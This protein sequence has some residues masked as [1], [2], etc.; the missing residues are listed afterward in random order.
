M[1]ADSAHPKNSSRIPAWQPSLNEIARVERA[2]A[3]W[4]PDANIPLNAVIRQRSGV[5]VNNVPLEEIARRIFGRAGSIVDAQC[6]DWRL[7]GAEFIISDLKLAFTF[8]DIARTS[9]V[10]ETVRRNQENARTA[11][12]AVLRFLPRCLP[13]L[14]RR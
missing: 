10:M 5:A 3:R 4:E 13:A 8:L 2:H 1:P 11:Y 7:V 12:N 14:L 9:L 6:R